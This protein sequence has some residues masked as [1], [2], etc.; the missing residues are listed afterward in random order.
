MN[1]KF[2]TT[3]SLF[4]H[5][6]ENVSRVFAGMEAHARKKYG[7]KL[8]ERKVQRP[9]AVREGMKRGIEYDLE[10]QKRKK[11]I[12]EAEAVYDRLIN[13]VRPRT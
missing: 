7:Q 13:P 10:N 8:W 11:L 4:R 3:F 1:D 9:S 12:A 2:G 6:E 5:D